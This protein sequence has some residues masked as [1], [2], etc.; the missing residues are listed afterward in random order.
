[1]A[2][3]LVL[4]MQGLL[5]LTIFWLQRRLRASG[6]NKTNETHHHD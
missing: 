2:M 5:I 1:M 3:L 4:A 6:K